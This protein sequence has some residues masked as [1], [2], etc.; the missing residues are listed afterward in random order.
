MEAWLPLWSAEGTTVL[1]FRLTNEW[2][3]FW[4]CFDKRSGRLQ[5]QPPSVSPEIK[6]KKKHHP[7]RSDRIGHRDG[8]DFPQGRMNVERKE[9]PRL[10]GDH[11]QIGTKI[12]FT[13]CRLE[14]KRSRSLKKFPPVTPADQPREPH[15]WLTFETGWPKIPPS[16]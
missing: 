14:D 16:F 13:V 9:E 4:W 7:Y 8:A 10:Q 12:G 1:R 6:K 15:V 11:Y 2:C 3:D 5:L